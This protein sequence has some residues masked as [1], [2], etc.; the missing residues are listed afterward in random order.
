MKFLKK[1]KL[2]KSQV[3]IEMLFAIGTILLLFTVVLIVVIDKRTE[4]RNTKNFLELRDDCLKISNTINEI[5]IDGDGTNITIKIKN[6]A[7]VQEN[8]LSV[9]DGKNEVYCTFPINVSNFT[10]AKGSVIFQ[11]QNNIVV[12]KNA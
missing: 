10:L 12:I 11:N 6:N 9:T 8:F 7:S 3:S 2:K 1:T 5:F 4:L